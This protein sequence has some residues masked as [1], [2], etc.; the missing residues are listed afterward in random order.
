VAPSR[1]PPPNSLRRCS[2]SVTLSRRPSRV[3]SAAQSA[4]LRGRQR[5][6]RQAGIWRY[7]GRSDH[8]A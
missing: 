5:A 2:R 8:C 3:I 4:G 7:L 1:S 6:Q